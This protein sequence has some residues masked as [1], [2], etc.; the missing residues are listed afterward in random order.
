MSQ[1]NGYELIGASESTSS[2]IFW[3][4]K[5]NGEFFFL[6]R[7]NDPCRPSNHMGAQEFKRRS[8]LCDRFEKE[9]R[10][11]NGVIAKVGGGNLVAPVDFFLHNGRYYQATPWRN[12][13]KKSIQ[14]IVAL[15]AP[16]KLLIMK[17]AA[18]CLKLLHEQGIVHCDMKPDNFPVT[19]TKSNTLTCSLID[20]DTAHFE[21][22]IPQ[23][24]DV[25]VTM[26]FMS[27]ELA[28]YKLHRN[29]YGNLKFNVKSDVF[30][31][32][33]IFHHYWSGEKFSYPTPKK[34]PYLY[35]AVLEGLPVSVSN[36]VPKWL[37]TLLLQMIAREPEK[38]PSMS[39]VLEYL[40]Q[41]DPSDR[42]GRPA[43]DPVRPTQPKQAVRQEQPQPQN[44]AYVKGPRFPDDA[45]RFEVLPN[46][47]V[48][49]VYDDGAR[50]GLSLEVAV[51]KQYISKK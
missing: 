5:K 28:S 26:P 7:F 25:S 23:P 40:K 45:V 30:A 48:L 41:V 19:V 1:I 10:S 44:G 39:Q 21:R 42:S 17:T 43:A 35:N 33:I 8:D 20:F 29:Y 12:I 31:M 46:D 38:R 37:E 2:A 15:G 34:G 6:K 24:D 32:A 49:F 47:K 16:Q 9:R 51:K 3:K 11:I 4:A 50:M 14:Q 13:E 36:K 27:P 22:D 18:N